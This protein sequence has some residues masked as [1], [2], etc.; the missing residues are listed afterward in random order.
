VAEGLR[1][2][3]DLAQAMFLSLFET[4]DA[5]SVVE[6]VSRGIGQLVEQLLK[7]GRAGEA[8]VLLER[9]ETAVG[10]AQVVIHEGDQVF[11]AD[12]LGPDGVFGPECFGGSD[13]E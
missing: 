11:G 8:E 1:H 12:V 3:T 5:S 10:Q 6:G 4:Y 13:F 2:D 7:D 9:L